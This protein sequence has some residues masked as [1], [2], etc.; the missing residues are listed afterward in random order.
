MGGGSYSYQKI[1]EMVRSGKLNESIVDTAVSR[2]LRVKF[3]LGLF[4]T[5]YTGAP[6][7]ELSKYIHTKET[8][9]LAR[10][11]DAESIIL[12]ENHNHTLPLSKSAN[13]AVI[14]PMAHGYMNVS[15]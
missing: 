10:Q 5:P 12:L 8:V 9:R 13:I 1:P 3:E 7:D 2:V 14:G 11:L 15:S 4:E 6:D